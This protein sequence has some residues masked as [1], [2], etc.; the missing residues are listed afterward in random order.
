MVAIITCRRYF[1]FRIRYCERAAIISPLLSILF[2]Y[3]IAASISRLHVSLMVYA[4]LFSRCHAVSPPYFFELSMPFSPLDA[5]RAADYAIFRLPFILRYAI[6]TT[7]LLSADFISL[8]SLITRR[9]EP[10]P[11]PPYAS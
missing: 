10:P 1:F 2:V 3:A 6:F 8:F 7:L 9:Y 5:Y 11:A 4:S